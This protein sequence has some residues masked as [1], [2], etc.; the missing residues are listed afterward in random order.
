MHFG[1]KRKLDFHSKEINRN[2]FSWQ[3]NK[4]VKPTAGLLVL[5]LFVR[6][7]KTQNLI[8][9]NDLSMILIG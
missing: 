7:R 6:L 9:I 1:R 2:F 3:Q 5:S 4:S 8:T